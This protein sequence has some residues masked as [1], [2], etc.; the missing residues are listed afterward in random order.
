MFSP[1]RMLAKFR[2]KSI[3]EGVAGSDDV[4]FG[5]FLRHFVELDSSESERERA[6]HVGKNIDGHAG[7]E[8]KAELQVVAVGVFHLSVGFVGQARRTGLDR[9]LQF[10]EEPEM[11][12]G[13]DPGVRT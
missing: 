2:R 11:A 8:R 10:G 12:F 4:S 6:A 1:I 5:V 3:F 9:E 7:I 13:I